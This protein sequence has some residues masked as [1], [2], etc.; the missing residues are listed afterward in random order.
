MGH[1]SDQRGRGARDHDALGNG[2]DHN[3]DTVQL[4]RRRFLAATALGGAAIAGGVGPMLA[5][6]PAA[7]VSTNARIIIVGA[8]A[9]GLSLAT[10]LARGLDGARIT[11]ID[12][13]EQHY[14]QPGLTLVATGA[15]KPQRVVDSNARYIDDSVEW[16]RDSVVD[17]DPDANRVHLASGSQRE[18]DYLLVA[19]G[20]KVDYA[21]IEGFEPSLIGTNGI[22]CVYDNPDHA[23][24][25][26]RAISRFIETG[27]VGVFN[28]PP[29]AIKC[30]GAPLKVTM[31][32]EH[33]LRQA[34]NRG[35]ATIEYIQPG[36]ALFSQP[37]TNDFLLEHF[38]AR[39]INVHWEHRL[40]GI[41]PGRREARLATPDGERTIQYDFLH[42]PPPMT[43]PD[44]VRNS[45][46]AAPEGPFT[47]W[48]EVD[49]FTMQHT[50]YPNVFGAGDVV[51]TPIGKTA[52]SVKAQVPVAA[53]NL[54]SL[55][56]GR[57]LRA[58]YD[59]Y[60]SCPLITER[61]SGILVEFDYDLKMVP[62]F[63]FISPY[64]EHWVPWLMKDR[65]LH[66]AY[67]AMLRGRV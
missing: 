17:F 30:A 49:Q 14:Y 5:S 39:G 59:G 38:P 45:A 2:G 44:S 67:N 4:Q 64:R 6:R 47:G 15:W 57:E 65:M 55:I 48:L 41:E 32:T 12:S 27:G 7:A 46:L 19:T 33:G 61:G 21:Q 52:A 31:L 50:R 28:R 63:P 26:W 43:A 51:G 37:D 56:Q 9:A 36:R 11:I 13:R 60:T 42:V 24:R 23:E 53:E 20:L 3:A 10:R 34:G 66:A 62:S 18:Y 25:T 1:E 35:K 8:G 54:I 22:G 40:I 29:G 16:L 58:R